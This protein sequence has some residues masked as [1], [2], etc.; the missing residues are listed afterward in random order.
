MKIMR[1]SEWPFIKED[2]IEADDG[3]D[4]HNEAGEEEEEERIEHWH[5]DD[6][7]EDESD[8]DKDKDDKDG[9][10]DSDDD[11]VDN[12]RNFKVAA[13]NPNLN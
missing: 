6:E 1:V 13:R 4:C 7:D 11:E 2:E 12:S 5:H 9:D 3:E 8:K 10:D